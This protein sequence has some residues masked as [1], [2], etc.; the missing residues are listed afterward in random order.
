MGKI[1]QIEK[2]LSYANPLANEHLDGIQNTGL[3]IFFIF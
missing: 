1:R 2:Y 3:R